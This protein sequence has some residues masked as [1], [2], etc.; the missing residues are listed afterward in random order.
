MTLESVTKNQLK[1]SINDSLMLADV[2]LS[3]DAV[4]T[5]TKQ[6]MIRVI[7]WCA[8]MHYEASDNPIRARCAP[9]CL[10]RL[11]PSDHYLQTWRVPQAKGRGKKPRKRGK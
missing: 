5:L 4:D 2:E 10:R 3:A 6:E 7:D 11:L 9:K 8:A 1:Q